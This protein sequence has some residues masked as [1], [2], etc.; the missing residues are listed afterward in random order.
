MNVGQRIQND[1]KEWRAPGYMG[2]RIVRADCVRCGQYGNHL[3]IGDKEIPLHGCWHTA[4]IYECATCGMWW[5]DV[6]A[7]KVSR[8]AQ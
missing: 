1:L 2:Y 4:P 6:L 7:A 8:I 3:Y 5:A